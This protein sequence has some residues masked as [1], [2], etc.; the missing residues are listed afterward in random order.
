MCFSGSSTVTAV[1][2]GAN[3]GTWS[4]SWRARGSGGQ[5]SQGLDQRSGCSWMRRSQGWAEFLSKWWLLS[6]VSASQDPAVDTIPS[7]HS[8][9]EGHRALA[10][11]VW[12]LPRRCGSRQDRELQVS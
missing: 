6:F 12:I 5:G 1:L 2:E 11:T 3:Q 10:L 8:E 7:G 9:L 4:G